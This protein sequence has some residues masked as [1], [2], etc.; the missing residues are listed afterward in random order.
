MTFI[1]VHI[2]KSKFK[3]KA[4]FLF[5]YLLKCLLLILTLDQSKKK[6]SQ[7]IYSFLSQLRKRRRKNTC[8]TLRL[9]LDV[10]FTS[11]DVTPMLLNNLSNFYL[12]L[13]NLT[14]GLDL[15]L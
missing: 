8:I 12:H 9:V 6:R 15:Y 14:F 10:V 11:F 2:L 1:S 13:F 3:K 5:R 4:T 7:N